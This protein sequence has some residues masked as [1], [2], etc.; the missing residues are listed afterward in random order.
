MKP[1]K[2]A[3]EVIR[4]R[5]CGRT[6][7]RAPSTTGPGGQTVRGRLTCRHCGKEV[8]EPKSKGS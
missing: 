1:D 2:P 4:C 7:L 5:A 3:R 6:D 8:R